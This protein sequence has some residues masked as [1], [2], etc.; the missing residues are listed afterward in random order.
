MR[1]SGSSSSSATAACSRPCASRA[2]A[3]R[4]VSLPLPPSARGLPARPRLRCRCRDDRNHFTPLSGALPPRASRATATPHRGED[5]TSHTPLARRADDAA[6]RLLARHTPSL[7]RRAPRPL[8]RLSP[9][10]RYLH[11][12]FV[13][14]YRPLTPKAAADATA[15]MRG[16]VFGS[17]GG[18]GDGDDSEFGG[19]AARRDAASAASVRALLAALPRAGVEGVAEGA[20]IGMTKVL[21]SS[22]VVAAPENAVANRSPQIRSCKS[23]DFVPYEPHP[24]IP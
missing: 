12:Q 24:R 6:P 18:S 17:G 15:S 16:R 1:G 10:V 22:C 23:F 2:P 9:Q 13:R 7:A 14:R 20:R 4:C 5:A 8:S 3:S 11:E 21:R 19:G